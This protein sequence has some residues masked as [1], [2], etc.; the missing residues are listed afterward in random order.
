MTNTNTALSCT[1]ATLAIDQDNNLDLASLSPDSIAYLLEYGL[2]KT[3]QDA[4]AGAIKAYGEAFSA[5][6][7]RTKVQTKLFDSGCELLDVEG[8]AVEVQYTA[9]TF[10]KAVA[11]TKRAARLTAL[12]A[13]NMRPSGLGS[14]LAGLDRI[15]RDVAVEMIRAACKANGVKM[16]D[17]D[18]LAEMAAALTAKNPAVMAEAERRQAMA[19]TAIDLDSLA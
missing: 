12:L 14:R 5:G 11:H 9:E 18:K 8:D 17:A 13:G 2:N 10:G 15:A 16:P 4:S 1:L 6:A 3:L 19:T 7:K